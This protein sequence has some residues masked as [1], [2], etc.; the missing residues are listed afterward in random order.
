MNKFT[1]YSSAAL[2]AYASYTFATCPCERACGCKVWAVG[3]AISIPLAYL[4]YGNLY[5]Q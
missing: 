2:L 4:V 5:E 1:Q 3:A